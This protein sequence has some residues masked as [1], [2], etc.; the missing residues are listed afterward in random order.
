MT[1]GKDC[2]LIKKKELDALKEPYLFAKKEFDLKLKKLTDE[3]YIEQTKL[4]EEIKELKDQIKNTPPVI[5]PMRIAI[6]IENYDK[7]SYNNNGYT[8]IPN[9]NIT[10]ININLDESLYSQIRKILHDFS[11]S[12]MNKCIKK[13]KEIKDINI[14]QIVKNIEEKCYTEVSNMEYFERRNFLKK[15]KEKKDDRLK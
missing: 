5:D 10:P 2:I 3:N 7:F 15:F 4:L 6:Y 9:T 1:T 13:S 8:Y 12:E 14:K 11:E